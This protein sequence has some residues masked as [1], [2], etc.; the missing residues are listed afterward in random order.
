[1]TR[2]KSGVEQTVRNSK[3]IE[4][5]DFVIIPA[6]TEEII[7]DGYKKNDFVPFEKDERGLVKTFNGHTAVVEVSGHSDRFYTYNPQDLIKEKYKKKYRK[8]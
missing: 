2:G 4:A 7:P 5:G 8:K 6:Q 3:R 1:M